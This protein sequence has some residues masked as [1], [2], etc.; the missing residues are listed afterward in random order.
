MRAFED[1]NPICIFVFFAAVTTPAMFCM[2]PVL[3][4]LSLLGAIS[5]FLARNGDKGLSSHLYILA[6]FLITA[7]INPIFY[8]NGATALFVVNDNPVTLEAVIYGVFAAVMITAV[9]YWFRSFSQ[10]M[11]GDRLLY[12]FGSLSP[13]LALLLSMTLRYIPLFGAQTKKVNQAQKALG[14]YKEDN[15][16]DRIRGGARVFSVMVTWGLENGIVT[17]DSMTARGYGVGRRTF[18]SLYRFRRSD[19]FLLAATLMLLAV[20]LSGIASGALDFDFYPR[21]GSIPA[22]P[23]SA[24]AYAAYGILAL[25]PTFCEAEEKVKWKY[26]KSKI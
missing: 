6:V 14:L 20:T 13:K 25:I 9:I 16:I 15:A 17:A 19:A 4:A 5:T 1:C 26:L 8:H 21:L 24:A 23:L 11:T 22:S 2:N 12:L 10:I 7:L 3:L 18:Y